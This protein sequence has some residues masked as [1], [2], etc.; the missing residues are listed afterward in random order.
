MTASLSFLTSLKSVS[1][2]LVL[3]YRKEDDLRKSCSWLGTGSSIAF[4]RRESHMTRMKLKSKNR[5]EKKL[6]RLQ[7]KK[8]KEDERTTTIQK[9]VASEK[10]ARDL[11]KPRFN[12]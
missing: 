6:K 2:Y 11:K 5:L 10:W 9:K 12:E 3:G 4:G 7:R 1:V 8:E